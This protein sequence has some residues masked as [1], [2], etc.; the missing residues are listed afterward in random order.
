[1]ILMM[2]VASLTVSAREM[3]FKDVSLAD[4]L[5]VLDEAYPESDL[6][7]VYDELEDFKV[8]KR[9]VSSSLREAV[10]EVIGFYPIGVVADGR[11][12]YVECRMHYATR[13]T[14][15][16]VNEYEQPVSFA[17][18]VLLNPADSSFIAGGVSNE[19]GRFV[20]PARAGEVLLKASAIGYFPFY[21]GSMVDD[22]GTLR[23]HTDAKLLGE[24]EV[25]RNRPTVV[26]KAD[27]TI[28]S[29][30]GV[31]HLQN[32]SLD[33]ILNFA[34]GVFVDKNGNISINGIGGVTVVVNDRQM[35]L[36]GDQL[37]SYLKSIQGSDIKSIEIMV[38]PTSEY[39]AE[40]S[41]GVICINTNRKRDAGLS[42]FV[43]TNFSFDKRST[44]TP[45]IGIAYSLRG[46]TAYGNYTFTDAR[47]VMERLT[48]DFY[49]SGRKNVLSESYQGNGKTHS[50]RVGIDW[51]IGT[52]HYVGVE[53]N[54]MYNRKSDDGVL[55][56][57]TFED[58]IASSGKIASTA[59]G[60]Y[61]RGNNMLNVNY[62]W[63]IDS[64]GQILKFVADYSDVTSRDD[65]DD[66]V[67][68]YYNANDE[69][70]N[71]DFKRQLSS[72]NAKIYSAKLDYEKPFCS[73]GWKVGAG[74]KFSEV[75]NDYSYRLLNWE[76]EGE[77]PQ[78]DLKF[79]DRFRYKEYLYAGYVNA[80][81]SSRLLD[82]NA[83][84]RGEYQHTD[85]YSFANDQRTL[86]DDFRV[87]PSAFIYWKPNLMSGFMAYYGMRINRPNYMLV[88]PFVIYITELS[89]K[90][91]NPDLKPM[92]TNV[93]E[94][95]YV[96]RN[97][98]YMSLR[99]E[100]TDNR[101]RDYSYTDGER[102][103]TS[104]TNISGSEKYYFNVYAPLGRDGW[105]SSVMLNMGMLTTE[106]QGVK[107]EALSMDLS[108]SNYFHIVEGIGMQMNF[109]YAPPYKDVF[110]EIHRHTIKFDVG[111][112]YSFYRDK[113]L[114]S[115]GVD[116]LFGSTGK[117]RVTFDYD[118]LREEVS[119]S[120]FPGTAFWLSLKYNFNIGKKAS[121]RQKEKS[122]SDEIRRL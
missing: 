5:I 21:Y 108:W 86:H 14:G 49:Q 116:D 70:I 45:S 27:R 15:R 73:T 93:I 36:T 107:R 34:P 58:G 42:G 68:H 90:T 40:G 121:S 53:Y 56:T 78:E 104:T 120:P 112:D 119:I 48:E 3:I 98:Y 47:D 63:R 18:V 94:L 38:N 37:A 20:I 7:F 77:L 74:L 35:R 55:M 95:T 82:V 111:L 30:E 114:L 33:R 26:R 81:F 4:V 1:M 8:T 59:F 101:I 43:S 105:E 32:K 23:M 50:Y 61:R 24:V 17:N 51:M 13:M 115:C 83:G 54:G 52:S 39:D 60:Q 76:N 66:Y 85:G 80:A 62:I 46:V 64:I 96:L 92:I 103:V 106:A 28:L 10:E 102:V 11:N 44:Y 57:E 122:N 25:K 19:E 97:R 110:Q 84:L 89:Y 2:V 109:M 16:L 67:N 100:F 9:V 87:F 71:T 117:R 31:T 99:S 118:N 29:V 91:G 6:H 88:N 79:K 12:L 41:G 65:A 69:M 72:E 75:D 113:W 22:V